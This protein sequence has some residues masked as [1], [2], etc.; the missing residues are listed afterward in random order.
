MKIT[1]FSFPGLNGSKLVSKN[2]KT[3]KLLI[4]FLDQV[5]S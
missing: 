3:L 5:Q 1:M 4:N 2:F